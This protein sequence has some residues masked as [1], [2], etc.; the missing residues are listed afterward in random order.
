MSE[1][2]DDV[3]HGPF[4][5]HSADDGRTLEFVMPDGSYEPMT[6]WERFAWFSFKEMRQRGFEPAEETASE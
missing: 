6:A 2:K 3:Y 4:P 5:K 1:I